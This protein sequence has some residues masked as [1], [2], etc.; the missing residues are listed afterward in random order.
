MSNVA[1]V[2]D[3]RG[4]VQ[5]EWSQQLFILPLDPPFPRLWGKLP[6]CGL[7]CQSRGN[8]GG[9]EKQNQSGNF[10]KGICKSQHILNADNPMLHL[11]NRISCTSSKKCLLTNSTF[12]LP[13]TEQRCFQFEGTFGN[14]Q[15]L[16]QLLTHDHHLS[17]PLLPLTRKRSSLSFYDTSPVERCYIFLNTVISSVWIS[18]ALLFSLLFYVVT[19]SACCV[20]KERKKAI[21]CFCG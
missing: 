14:I 18:P 4:V 6:P 19:G 13:P 12:V 11:K 2:M 20:P 1:R 5:V 16:L 21:F 7:I 8:R 10:F 9:G 15:N 3:S 17:P